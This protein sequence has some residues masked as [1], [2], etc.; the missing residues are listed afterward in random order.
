MK[1]NPTSPILGPLRD[2]A[3]NEQA[4]AI[5]LETQRWGDEP[6][7]PRCGDMNVY[8]MIGMNGQRNKDYRWRCRS[9]GPE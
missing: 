9:T 8:R 3:Q 2:A 1:K 7:C 4:A 5:F 6:C